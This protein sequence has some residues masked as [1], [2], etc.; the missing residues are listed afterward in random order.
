MLAISNQSLTNSYKNTY[1]D[2]QLCKSITNEVERLL[3]RRIL[4]ERNVIDV[5]EELSTLLVVNESQF[6]DD[7][8]S[9]MVHSIFRERMQSKRSLS[10]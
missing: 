2:Y 5:R 8:V 1:K 3:G 10:P 4:T 7:R 6:E 9:K